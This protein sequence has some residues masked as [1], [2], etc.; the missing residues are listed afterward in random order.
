MKQR[1]DAGVITIHYRKLTGCLLL[2][3][4]MFL[5]TSVVAAIKTSILGF[6][7]SGIIQPDQQFL[8]SMK[9]YDVNPVLPVWFTLY[10]VGVIDA[11]HSGN[12]G[13]DDY[14]GTNTLTLESGQ[15]IL[16]P[17]PYLLDIH[18]YMAPQR[19][20]F[21]LTEYG[22]AVDLVEDSL[23]QK[24]DDI[25][26][27]PNVSREQVRVFSRTF[28]FTQNIQANGTISLDIN[29]TGMAGMRP[30]ALYVVAGQGDKPEALTELTTPTTVQVQ[31]T[32]NALH[33]ESSGRMFRLDPV[34]KF[35]IMA[36]IVG[37]GIYLRRS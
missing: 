22:D 37:V 18:T 1:G 24:V 4:S 32:V 25:S 27:P 28:D 31:E 6:Q 2:L 29:N 5:S 26:L 3:C 14:Q 21:N 16:Q 8:L 12:A 17:D 34:T 10:Y 35:L 9:L 20:N 33:G 23:D 13:S 36:V 15:L 30:L 11:T 19:K 7:Q